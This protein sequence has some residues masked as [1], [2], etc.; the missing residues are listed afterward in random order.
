MGDYVDDAAW[1]TAVQRPDWYLQLRPQYEELLARARRSDRA[2]AKRIADEVYSFFERALADQ[3]ICV[4]GQPPDWDAERRAIDTAVVHHTALPPGISWERLDAI[5]LTRVYARY[6]AEPDLGEAWVR[7]LPITSGHIR[8][9]RQVFYAYHWL[10]RSDGDLE[11]LLG[12]EE[13]GWHAGNW[14][15][16]CRSVGICIDDDLADKRPGPR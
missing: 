10:V 7:G 11:R 9:G 5:H 14:D 3:R 8:D 15:V 13:T 16:N 4:D 6:Y 1:L 2:T 12:D